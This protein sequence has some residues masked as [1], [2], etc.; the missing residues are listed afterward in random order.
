[1]KNFKLTNRIFDLLL[2]AVMM[3]GTSAQAFAAENSSGEIPMESETVYADQNIAAVIGYVKSGT[4]GSSIT[5]LA[6]YLGISKTFTVQITSYSGNMSG[7]QFVQAYLFRQSDN[8]LMASW[9]LGLN[10]YTGT[11]SFTLPK[12]GDYSMSVYNGSGATINVVGTWD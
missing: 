8:K 10:N 6:P 7:N 9:K 4:S 3:L 12:Q 5:H 2:A 11:A 1:M